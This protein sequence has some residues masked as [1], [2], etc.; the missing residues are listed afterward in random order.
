MSIAPPIIPFDAF[1]R[2]VNEA[3]HAPDQT[4]GI[5]TSVERLRRLG[6]TDAEIE[7]ARDADGWISMDSLV[8]HQQAR[9]T[10]GQTE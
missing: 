1:F 6:F 2:E 3:N 7:G 4:W 5:R 9:R 8:A 10:E